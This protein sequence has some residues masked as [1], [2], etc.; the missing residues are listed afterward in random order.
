MQAKKSLEKYTLIGLPGAGKTY[1]GKIWAEELKLKFYDL[2]E[3]IMKEMGQSIPQIF[4]LMGETYFRKIDENGRLE[5]SGAG[6]LWSFD[7]LC[8][9]R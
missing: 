7:F 6:N 8:F 9:Q 3:L 4:D 5:E 1:Y 2:D